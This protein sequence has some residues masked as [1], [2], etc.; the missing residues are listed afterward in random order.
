MVEMSSATHLYCSRGE[1]EEEE[2]EE[3]HF[4]PDA[5][6]RIFHHNKKSL[7]FSGLLESHSNNSSDNYQLN[8]PDVFYQTELTAWE[9]KV[10]N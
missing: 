1:E 5:I 3:L 2:K 8:V 6:S 9:K 4:L 7:Q 10:V